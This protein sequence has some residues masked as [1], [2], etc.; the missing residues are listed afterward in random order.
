MSRPWAADRATDQRGPASRDGLVTAVLCA[1]FDA[2]TDDAVLAARE[3]LL[4]AGMR[5]PTRPRHRPHLTLA[6]ARVHVD[7]LPAVVRASEAMA[8]EHAPVALALSRVGTFTRAGALWLGP[9]DVHGPP[10][11]RALQQSAV[12]MI[13]G[14]GWA[15][16]FGGRSRDGEWVAHCSLAT[17]LPADRLAELQALVESGYRPIDA[18]VAGIAVIVVGGAGDAGLIAL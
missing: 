11:L 1:A 10:A 9:A 5:R 17:R 12:A 16:A 3:V 6:A 14:S 15:P 4:R 8:V 2:R 7:Q 13:A 18:V